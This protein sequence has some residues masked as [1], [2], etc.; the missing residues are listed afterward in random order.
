MLTYLDRKSFEYIGGTVWMTPQQL[1]FKEIHLD[2]D[3][4]IQGDRQVIIEG[5]VIEV[6]KHHT[7]IVLVDS[8]ARLLVSTVGLLDVDLGYTAYLKDQ[9]LRILGVV[10]NGKKGLP[11]V[12]AVAVRPMS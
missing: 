4:V 1:T 9:K 7:Y 3:G 11:Y 5:Q 6:G 12:R 8:E 10:Q 2:V